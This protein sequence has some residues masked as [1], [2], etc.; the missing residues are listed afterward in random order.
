[1]L[2]SEKKE[3]ALKLLS[4]KAFYLVR[5]TGLEPVTPCTSNIAVLLPH[6]FSLFFAV[7]L[8][9]SHLQAVANS[10]GHLRLLTKN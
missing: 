3:K 10:Q 5:G 8:S 1:M 9:F 6:R 4:F 2:E 7:F